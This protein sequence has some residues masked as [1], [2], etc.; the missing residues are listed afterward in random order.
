MHVEHGA[1]T[2]SN[3]AGNSE[4]E[5]DTSDD[6]NDKTETKSQILINPDYKFETAKKILLFTSY[7][8]MHDWNFG[9]GHQPF[10]DHNCPVTNCYITNKRDN[11]CKYNL[12]QHFDFQN[13]LII[14]IFIKIKSMYELRAMFYFQQ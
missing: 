14:K 3:V 6:A 1:S 9:F 11:I 7:F 12:Y 2:K 8:G 10:I 13:F 4:K 5:R